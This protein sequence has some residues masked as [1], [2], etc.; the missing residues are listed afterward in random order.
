M[1]RHV[2]VSSRWTVFR[3]SSAC[4]TAFSSAEPRLLVVVEVCILQGAPES[5]SGSR[6]KFIHIRAQHQRNSEKISPQETLSC[7]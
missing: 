4:V 7:S 2:S 1:S 3:P 5:T 6:I